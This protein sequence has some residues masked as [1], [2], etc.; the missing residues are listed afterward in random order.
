MKT[1]YNSMA[2]TPEEV[3]KGLFTAFLNVLTEYNKKNINYYNEIHVYTDGCC[4]IIEWAQVPV[5]H[6]YGGVFTYLDED[7]VIMKEIRFPDGHYEYAIDGEQEKEM[8]EEFHKNNPGWVKTPYGSWTNEIENK[9]FLE[10]SIE[11]LE[12]EEKCRLE[13]ENKLKEK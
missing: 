2:F 8:W 9:K 10:S 3:E 1:E 13:E 5:D 7:H 12:K 11:H 6:D 4:Q